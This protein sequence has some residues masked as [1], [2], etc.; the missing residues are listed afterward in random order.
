LNLKL[1]I[2]RKTSYIDIRDGHPRTTLRSQ[3]G[4]RHHTLE[5]RI[6]DLQEAVGGLAKRPTQ[7]AIKMLE[8]LI[9]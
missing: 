2:L 1:E 6:S 4:S 9:K 5:R 7:S 3:N 8:T